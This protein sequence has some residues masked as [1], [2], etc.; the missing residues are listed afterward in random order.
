M[1]IQTTGLIF[2]EMTKRKE[3]DLLVLHHQGTTVRQTVEQIH[4]YHKNTNGWAGIGYH[5]YVRTNGEIIEGRPIEYVGA[6]A[7]GFNNN[8]IGICFEGNFEVEEMSNAQK[9]AGKWLVAYIKGIYPIEKVV[10]HRDLMATACPGKNFPFDEIANAT[11]KPPIKMP[12]DNRFTV[13]EWQDAAIKDGFKFAKFGADGKWGKEC[14]SVAKKAV[15]R[16][17]GEDDYRY[18]NLTRLIQQRL[19][20]EGDD[21]DGLFGEDTEE[22]VRKYQQIHNLEVDG[23]VGINTWKSMLGV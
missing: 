9:E 20:F 10:G 4:N 13:K 7:Y 3:T 8:S 17:R 11:E 2:G 14:E 5:F 15:C 1:N 19:G 6:H 23:K 16:N 22:A 21:L 12:K 18:K